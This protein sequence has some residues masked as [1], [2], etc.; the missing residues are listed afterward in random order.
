MRKYLGYLAC[1]LAI[2]A[3]ARGVT[4]I[5]I[6]FLA[7]GMTLMF[8]KERRNI[9]IGRP[10]AGKQN[11]FLDGIYFFGVQLLIMFVC[12]LIGVFAASSAD[13]MFGMFISGRRSLAE[14]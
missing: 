8:A 10:S 3:G 13:E 7:L 14:G 11:S 9:D 6:V 4:N 5:V 12:Y 1:A 2:I